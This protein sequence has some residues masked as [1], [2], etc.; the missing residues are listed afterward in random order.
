MITDP[1]VPLTDR[2]KKSI[3]EPEQ[4]RTTQMSLIDAAYAATTQQMA[5]DESRLQLDDARLDLLNERTQEKNNLSVPALLEEL[6]NDWGMAW[7]DI[8]TIAGVS[9]SAIRKW[10]KGGTATPENR[11]RLARIDAFLST[12]ADYAVGDPAQWMEMELPLPPGYS[13]R[14]LDLFMRGQELALL[15]IAEQK[16]A[17]AVLDAI[18]PSWR[19]RRS[20]FE[21]VTD[22]DGH[23]TIRRRS[24]K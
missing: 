9:V 13:I 11:Q 8:A 21:V 7:S 1:Y 23:R 17:A 20:D 4:V 12:L 16:P 2:N 24:G 22:T 14:P 19:D 15:K 5:A 18:N 6:A 10:R 3:R